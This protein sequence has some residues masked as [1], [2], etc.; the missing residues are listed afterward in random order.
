VS[1]HQHEP[2]WRPDQ[3]QQPEYPP[4]EPPT[5]WQRV[6]AE[7]KAAQEAERSAAQDDPG[8]SD[9]LAA[10]RPVWP[11]GLTDKARV[12]LLRCAEA[13][14]NTAKRLRAIVGPA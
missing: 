8:D 3:V 11:A 5:A 6:Q 7:R 9:T 12:E 10:D 2:G 4:P 14:E 13:F 1:E